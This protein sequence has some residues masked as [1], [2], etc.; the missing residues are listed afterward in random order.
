MNGDVF[1]KK[2]QKKN[3]KT[4]NKIYI[5]NSLLAGTVVRQLS[6]SIDGSQMIGP[7]FYPGHQLKYTEAYVEQSFHPLH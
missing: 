4:H 7:G 6:S 3:K 1:G 2:Y 5:T